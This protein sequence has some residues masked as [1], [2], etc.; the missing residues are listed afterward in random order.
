MVQKKDLLF[1]FCANIWYDVDFWARVLI[2][3][4]KNQE[5]IKKIPESAFLCFLSV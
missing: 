2:Y 3:G 1:V 4:K 5:I